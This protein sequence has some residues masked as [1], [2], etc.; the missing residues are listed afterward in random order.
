MIVATHRPHRDLK[1]PGDPVRLILE[2]LPDADIEAIVRNVGRSSTL[3]DLDIR[4]IASRV[5][6]IPLFAEEFTSAAVDHW[7]GGQRGFDLPETIQASVMSR[8]DMLGDAKSVAQV[9]SVLGR[10]FRLSQLGVLAAS[11]LTTLRDA[12]ARLVNSGLLLEGKQLGEIY[13]FKH[14]L[15]RDVAY[16]SLPRR[17]RS[18][19]HRR[20]V[21]DILLNSTAE[22]Q[23]EVIAYHLT[24][25]GLFLEAI[26]YWKTAGYSASRASAHVESIAH[27]S[28]GLD[29]INKLPDGRPRTNLEFSFQVGLMG[30][31]IASKGYTSE[32]LKAAISRALALSQA[33]DKTPEIYAVTL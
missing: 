31:L 18:A 4:M 23:P 12:I 21:Y 30:P 7:I 5:E 16:G 15:V 29:L 27:F 11:K 26:D 20:L 17:T 9:A 3:S 19:L 24:E 2:R 10:T 33:I 6:G 1:L 32:E 14:A 25:A 28:K 13:Q 8:L 22:R